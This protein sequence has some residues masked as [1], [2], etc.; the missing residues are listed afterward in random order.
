VIEKQDGMEEDES[1]DGV[2]DFRNRRCN[3]RPAASE[4]K[5]ACMDRM[6]KVDSGRTR[7]CTF[8]RWPAT[9]ENAGRLYLSNHA[10]EL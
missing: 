9:L 10:A 4:F 6:F 7:L 1:E 5:E 3:I 8:H 2:L